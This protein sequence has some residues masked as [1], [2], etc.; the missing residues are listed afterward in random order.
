MLAMEA[1]ATRG[2]R[3][4]ALSLTSIASVLAPAGHVAWGKRQKSR[5]SGGLEKGG[6]QSCFRAFVQSRAACAFIRY[7]RASSL[8]TGLALRHLAFRSRPR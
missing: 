2:A 5:A 4:P 3:Q 6:Q 8:S 1:R 7:A